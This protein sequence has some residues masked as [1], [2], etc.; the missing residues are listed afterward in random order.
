MEVEVDVDVGDG[1]AGFVDNAAADRVAGLELEE[2]FLGDRLT[3]AGGG[4]GEL[5]GDVA[6]LVGADR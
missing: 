4:E 1:V 5:D 6:V 3:G 2:V